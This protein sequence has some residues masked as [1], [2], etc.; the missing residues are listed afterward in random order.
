MDLS[1]SSLNKSTIEQ[2]LKNLNYQRSL[3]LL[4]ALS[5]LFT[6]F[7]STLVLSIDSLKDWII[8][9]WGWALFTTIIASILLM[10]ATFVAAVRQAPIN[11]TVYLLF[12]LCF[13]YA[14]G[15]LSARD[16]YGNFGWQ[17]V[18][19]MLWILTSIAVVFAVYAMF[20]TNYMD[21]MTSILLTVGVSMFVLFGFSIFS[22]INFIKLILSM[23][24][25]VIFGYYLNYDVRMM[26]RGNIYDTW[27]ED[28][29]SGAVRIWLEVGFVFCRLVELIGQMFQKSKQ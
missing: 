26:V 10:A 14:L 1:R 21:S 8:G 2:R 12:T 15:Y 9:N 25:V 5:L 27:R 3:Y 4:F 6:L 13:A 18:Y 29:V 24:P 16:W 28:P 22:K 11:L 23:V 17:V 19:Y 20:A 7:W